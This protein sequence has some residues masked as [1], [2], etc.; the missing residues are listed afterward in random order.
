MLC[1]HMTFMEMV[2]IAERS[3]LNDERGV[4]EAALQSRAKD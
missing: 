2:K 3:L 1:I 4:E